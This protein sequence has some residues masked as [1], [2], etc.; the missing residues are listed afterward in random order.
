MVL[1]ASEANMKRISEKIERRVGQKLGL[2][3]ERCASPKCALTRRPTPPGVHGSSRSRRRP[4]ERGIQMLEKKKVAA[5]YGLSARTLKNVFAVART[6][7]GSKKGM[8]NVV[9]V[10]VEMLERRLDSV[11]WRLGLAPSRMVA[12]QLVSHGHIIVNARKVDIPSFLVSVGET[13]SVKPES[14]TSPLFKNL[15]RTLPKHQPFS[16]LKLN[17]NEFSGILIS[18]PLREEASVPVD[19]PKI[20]ELYAGS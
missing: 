4:T 14:R 12:R 16:W 20:A 10:V 19:F 2:K 6:T 9:D 15:E 17:A 5:L 11:V 18:S 13:V 3:A 1:R 8:R 7:A